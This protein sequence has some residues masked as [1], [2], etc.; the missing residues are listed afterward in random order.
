MQEREKLRAKTLN[1]DLQIK[2]VA[3]IIDGVVHC[4]PPPYR[5][6][7]LVRVLISKGVDPTKMFPQYQGF[8]ILNGIFINRI[9]AA[10][11]ALI[12]GQVAKLYAPPEL[13]SEDLW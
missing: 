9:K 13:F 4:L 8:W 3:C 5:H 11:I 1:Y 2:G 6:Y 10:K 12:N 7:H